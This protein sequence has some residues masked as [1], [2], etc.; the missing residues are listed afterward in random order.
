MFGLSEGEGADGAFKSELGG[1][2]NDN[3][4]TSG[5]KDQTALCTPSGTFNLTPQLNARRRA[6]ATCAA[7][8]GLRHQKNRHPRDVINGKT[9]S[10]A[11]HLQGSF[12]N[13]N[14]A[15]ERSI[16]LDVLGCWSWT[17]M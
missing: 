6:R 3:R 10:W 12:R 2:N 13:T 14:K 8:K 4:F 1:T 16:M 11:E 15:E 5:K 17:H 7:D 9:D